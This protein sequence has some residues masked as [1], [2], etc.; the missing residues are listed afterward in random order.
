MQQVISNVRGEFHRVPVPA[1]TVITASVP[2]ADA[3]PGE[4]IRVQAEDGGLLQGRAAQ[5]SVAVGSDH[6]ASV[7]F[8]T[9]AN[10]GL[11]RVTLRRGGECR[12]LQFWVGP[13]PPVLVR[14]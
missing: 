5:G 9:A 14:Q 12:V 6:R 1:S 7:A 2:F 13:E 4:S 3:V 11:Y 10:D 8:Q